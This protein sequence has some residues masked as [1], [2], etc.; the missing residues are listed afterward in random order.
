[1]VKVRVR[2]RNRVRVRVRVGVELEP[3]GVYYRIYV[4]GGKCP[5]TKMT[6]PKKRSPP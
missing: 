3:G 6:Y 4:T 1:M 5:R 2:V